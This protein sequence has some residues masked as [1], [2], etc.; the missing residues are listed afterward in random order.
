MTVAQDQDGFK[1][2]L[3]EEGKK[4]DCPHC[5]ELMSAYLVGYIIKYIGADGK[6]HVKCPTCGEDWLTGRKG[7][8]MVRQ[9]AM[10][11]AKACARLYMECLHFEQVNEQADEAK[12]D[13]RFDDMAASSAGG[14]EL[15][16]V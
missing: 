10:R 2:W 9:A 11:H 3:L 14:E 1:E 5:E 7:G 16:G 6:K 12:A 13:A 4:D 8:G 15:T